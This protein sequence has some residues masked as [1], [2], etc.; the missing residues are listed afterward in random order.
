MPSN[1]EK[2]RILLE[3]IA[4]LRAQ[5][6]KQTDNSA[7]APMTFHS[8]TIAEEAFPKGRFS[9]ELASDVIGAGAPK[10]PRAGVE[11]PEALNGPEPLGYPI[12][13]LDEVAGE[14]FEVVQAQRILDQREMWVVTSSDAH[15][16]AAAPG[17]VPPFPAP[18]ERSSA[19]LSQPRIKRR[20]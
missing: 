19:S 2:L 9:E 15:S 3:D 1:A 17:K 11:W 18:I 12:D 7:P 20:I 13:A 5:Q 8:R 10:Y 16:T 14:P 4:A 6:P